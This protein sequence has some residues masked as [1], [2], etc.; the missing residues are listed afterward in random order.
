MAKEKK[1]NF[2]DE[3]AFLLRLAKKKRW[4]QLEEKRIGEEIELQS[5]LNNLMM[6][7]REK[8]LSQLRQQDLNDEELIKLDQSIN[9]KCD[10]QI[11]DL[12]EMFAQLDMRRKV[13]SISITFLKV[14]TTNKHNVCLMLIRREICR[15]TCVGRSVLRS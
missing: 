4:N 13:R 14:A 11:Q 8:Q 10:Q 6:Q 7:D 12:N 1:L 2:G 3:I 5:Y 9:S 15:I